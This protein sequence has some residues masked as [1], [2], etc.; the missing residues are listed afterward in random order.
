[1]ARVL[2]VLC[3]WCLMAVTLPASATPFFA[4]TYHMKCEGCH[5]GFPRLNAF[6]LRFKANNFRIPG[7]EKDAPMAWEKTIPLAAQVKPQIMHFH[8]GGV[9]SQFTDTQALSGGLLTK[10]T[11]YYIHHTLWFDD[12]PQAFPSWELWAQQVLSERNKIM[13]KVGQFELPYSYSPEINRTTISYPLIFFAAG[14]QPNDITIGGAVSGLQV[15]GNAPGHVSLYLV[16]GA[17]AFNQGGVRVGERQWWGR[18]RDVFL[19]AAVGPVERQGAVFAYF[20]SPPTGATSDGSAQRYGLDGVYFVDSVKLQLHGMA[21]YG[22]NDNP[23]RSGPKGTVRA[24]FVEA[25]HMFGKWVGLTGRLDWATSDFAAGRSYQ[26]A[27]TL[28][29]RVYPLDHLKLVAEVQ[30]LAHGGSSEAFMA[31]VSF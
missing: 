26:D 30:W 7:S 2:A 12:K 17:P 21:V 22:E 31:A 25:D 19:R 9:T 24:A 3:V 11:A 8:P 14:A 28:S 16:G 20:A 27:K 5:D 13:L 15:S 10:Q 29:L 4:R 1:M 18:F 23:A 6:G